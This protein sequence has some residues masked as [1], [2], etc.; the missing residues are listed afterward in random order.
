MTDQNS[1]S[2]LFWVE[3]GPPTHLYQN[4]EIENSREKCTF[5]LYYEFIMSNFQI[6]YS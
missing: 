5:W 6:Y 3:F 4:S 2:N 1:K